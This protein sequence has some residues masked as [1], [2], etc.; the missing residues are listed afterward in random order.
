M[1]RGRTGDFTWAVDS[2]KRML[3]AQFRMTLLEQMLSYNPLNNLYPGDTTFRD[4]TQQPKKVRSS[5]DGRVAAVQPR[6]V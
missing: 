4:Y 6:K 5:V 2:K 3:F 1:L